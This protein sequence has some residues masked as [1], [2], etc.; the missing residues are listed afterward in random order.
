MLIIRRYVAR[1]LRTLETFRAKDCRP[2]KPD[3]KQ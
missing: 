1:Y 3:P 2:Q